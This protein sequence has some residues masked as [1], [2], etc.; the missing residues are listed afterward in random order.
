MEAVIIVADCCMKTARVTG[1]GSTMIN[2]VSVTIVLKLWNQS[3]RRKVTE[4]YWNLNELDE[5]ELV[6]KTINK[7]DVD[8]F[9]VLI[10]CRDG[11]KFV[12]NASDGGCSSWTTYPSKEDWSFL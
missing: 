5:Q 10:V 11:T 8:G 1:S 4:M 2:I 7:I 12:Y 6:G 9:G 3:R